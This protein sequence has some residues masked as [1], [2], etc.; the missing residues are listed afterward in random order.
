MHNYFKTQ[1]NY[2]VTWNAPYYRDSLLIAR[3]N[4]TIKVKCEG[5][6]RIMTCSDRRIIR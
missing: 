4:N 3:Q 5:F 2:A 6:G 1:I